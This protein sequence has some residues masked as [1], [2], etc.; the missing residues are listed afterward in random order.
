MDRL[1]GISATKPSAMVHFDWM[2]L[3]F[4]IGQTDADRN[5]YSV[6]EFIHKILDDL[7]LG[8]RS[9]EH[10]SELQSLV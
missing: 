2:T 3:V 9:E 10:T 5:G 8:D 4:P 6:Y 7:D 1:Q